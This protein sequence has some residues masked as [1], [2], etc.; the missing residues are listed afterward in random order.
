[1]IVLKPPDCLKG[2]YYKGLASQKP[3]F[4]IQLTPKV[5]SVI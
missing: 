4:Q 2:F 1:M 5:G 3:G